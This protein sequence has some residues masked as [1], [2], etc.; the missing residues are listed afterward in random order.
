MRRTLKI[1]HTLGSVGMMGGMAACLVLLVV[2]HGRAPE[3]AAAV[4]AGLDLVVRWLI[5]P[6][7]PL[8]LCSGLL[9]MAVHRPFHNAGWVWAKAATGVVTLEGT[10]GLS[11]RSHELAVVSERALQAGALATT[12]A[13]PSMPLASLSALADS[14]SGALWMLLVVGA[15]NVILGVWR[16][17]QRRAARVPDAG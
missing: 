17:R 13:V 12:G 2:A 7:V 1:L 5:F 15:A 14:E 6:S 4:Y 9:A 8:C 3:Q 10:F 11:S 16:P